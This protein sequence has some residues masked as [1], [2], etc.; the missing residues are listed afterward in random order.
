MIIY[1]TKLT[2]ERYKIKMPEDYVL[3]KDVADFILER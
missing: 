2:R 3:N 1:T